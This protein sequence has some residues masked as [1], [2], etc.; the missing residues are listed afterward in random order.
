M[1]II[2]LH[3][4]LPVNTLDLTGKDIYVRNNLTDGKNNLGMTVVNQTDIPRLKEGSVKIICMASSPLKITN[5]KILISSTPA[6]D[7]L[8]YISWI[9]SIINTGDTFAAVTKIKHLQSAKN[10]KKI[11][12]IL[13]LEGSEAFEE[14]FEYIDIFY[15]LGV[16]MVG[17]CWNHDNNFCTGATTSKKTG[18]TVAGKKLVKYLNKKGITIDTAHMSKK[19]FWDTI[20]LSTKPIICSHTN[21]ESLNPNHNEGERL[22]DDKQ[23]KAIMKNGGVIGISAVAPY[24]DPSREKSSIDTYIDQIEYI[25]KLVGINHVAIGGDFDGML[26]YPLTRGL[27][28]I[29][30]Y[31][32]IP[33]LL[34]KRGYSNK[35]IS[36][37]LYG[38]AHRVFECS[39]SK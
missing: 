4:D 1:R 27:E 14:G 16:R 20:K 6:K 38:N 25:I 5:N 23:I 10:S 8:R 13:T 29:S 19:S 11:G 7:T 32:K 28:E 21:L 3:N 12:V 35:E 2:D 39:W 9:H 34:S 26:S 30:Q 37:I 36:Q 22:L 17:I 33:K 31:K 18:L 24:I 15:D